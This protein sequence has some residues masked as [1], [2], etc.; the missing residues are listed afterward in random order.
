MS[1]SASAEIRPPRVLLHGQHTDYSLQVA[2]GRCV[3]VCKLQTIGCRRVRR[4]RR[5]DALIER[6]ALRVLHYSRQCTTAIHHRPSTPTTLVR[7]SSLF[8]A[9]HHGRSTSRTERRVRSHSRAAE[10]VCVLSSVYAV[11]ARSPLFTRTFLHENA[12]A[13]AIRR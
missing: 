10:V 8:L 12:A 3:N 6:L 2:N 13:L 1:G 11:N 4:G 9:L 7:S 5:P